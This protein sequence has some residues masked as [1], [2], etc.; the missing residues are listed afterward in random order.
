MTGDGI[1]PTFKLS[2]GLQKYSPI[3]VGELFQLF[4]WQRW[5]TSIIYCFSY[6]VFIQT[7]MAICLIHKYFHTKDCS[8][9][10]LKKNKKNR[11]SKMISS[12][13]SF[14]SFSP[15]ELVICN[16]ILHL[17]WKRIY[18]LYIEIA[19]LLT[20]SLFSESSH[21]EFFWMNKKIIVGI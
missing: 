12:K 3:V 15:K 7:P 21:Q 1:K 8:Y 4:I 16:T 13:F 17:I 19:W 2:I 9:P 14:L 6:T 20:F 18:T 5:I 11:L 10:L